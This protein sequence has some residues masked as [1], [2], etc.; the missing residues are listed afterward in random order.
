M[1]KALVL[2]ASGGMGYALV[3]EL[4]SREIEVIAFA[5]NK[6]KM[7]RLYESKALVTIFE[8]DVCNREQ[9][10]E[11]VAS[12]DII[13]HAI[14]V[15]YQEWSEK[16]PMI[17][18]AILDVAKQHHK[19]LAIVDNIYAYEKS[20]GTSINEDYPK[21]PPTKK[22]KIRLDLEQMAKSSDVTMFLAHFP[23]FYG[24]NAEN[25]QIHYFLQGVLQNKKAMF[26]GNQ[27]VPREYIYTPDGAKA[28]VELSLKEE[29]YGHHWNIPGSGVIT[30]EEIVSIVK[31]NTGY[32]KSVSTVTKTM[33]RFLGLFDGGMREFVE[34]F[35][36]NEQPTVLSGKRTEQLIGPLPQTPYQDGLKATI[37]HMSR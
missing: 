5:R 14:N 21:N 31:E 17:M 20:N 2:G 11:A 10:S 35:Y 12:V 28:M 30:G 13:F 33:I 6:D 25:T 29:A 19:K 1:K 24:P 22:G 36:L 37:L 4:L 15:P 18:R 8:G 26:I 34:M 9:L 16:Q 32:Q 23:D 3:C 7:Q 27:E